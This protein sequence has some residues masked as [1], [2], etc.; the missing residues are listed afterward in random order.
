MIQ[1]IKN[2]TICALLILAV[3]IAF[4]GTIA[5]SSI[6]FIKIIQT[7]PRAQLKRFNEMYNTFYTY[8]EWMMYSYEIKKAHPFRLEGK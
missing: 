5:I 7:S 8:D 2:F 3:L 6:S 4:G 1:K